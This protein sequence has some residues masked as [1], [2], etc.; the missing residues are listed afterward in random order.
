MNGN[1]GQ[2]FHFARISVKNMHFSERPIAKEETLS[3]SM[4]IIF[5]GDERWPHLSGWYSL[6]AS[7]V[8]FYLFIIQ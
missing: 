1:Q 6:R 8:L 4:E 5:I 7:D 3:T 2:T